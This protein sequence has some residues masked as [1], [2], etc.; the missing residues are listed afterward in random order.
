MM[1]GGGLMRAKNRVVKAMR[2]GLPMEKVASRA[3]WSR[4]GLYLHMPELLEAVPDYRERRLALVVK[5]REDRLSRLPVPQPARDVIEAAGLAGLELKPVRLSD[6]DQYCTRRLSARKGRVLVSMARRHFSFG[7]STAY[8][9][10][11]LSRRIVR[12]RGVAGIVLC[13]HAK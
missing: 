13:A 12:A 11:R 4:P 2:E 1:R 6:N 5:E 9:P 8:A 7:S 10:F 3:G